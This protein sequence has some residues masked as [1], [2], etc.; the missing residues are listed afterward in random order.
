MFECRSLSFPT[1]REW[2]P[3]RKLE[4][5]SEVPG[6]EIDRE[7]STSGEEYP[8]E[9]NR[10]WMCA[11][12]GRSCWVVVRSR[13]RAHVHIDSRRRHWLSNRDNRRRSSLQDCFLAFAEGAFF[14]LST[15]KREQML[16]HLIS[17]RQSPRSFHRSIAGGLVYTATC[18][19]LP[20]WP[21]SL[22]RKSPSLPL[23][24]IKDP[25][26]IATLCL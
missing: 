12:L 5:K 18:P 24:T 3:Y 4:G 21:S 13:L 9:K 17:G 1:E 8:A 11:L 16:P 10:P 14:G 7:G 2:L 25:R 6:V 20:G 19:K 22:V 23:L 26:A 15:I